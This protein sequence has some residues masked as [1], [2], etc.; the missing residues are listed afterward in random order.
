M[1][2]T[3]S[4]FADAIIKNKIIDGLLTISDYVYNRQ[5]GSYDKKIR[6]EKFYENGLLIWEKEFNKE[7]YVGTLAVY[8]ELGLKNNNQNA[9]K[10]N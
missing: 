6:K 7:E 2:F 1:F 9:F 4:M 3:P 5:T 10:L 8:V